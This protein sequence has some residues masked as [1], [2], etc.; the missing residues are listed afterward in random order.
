MN[1]ERI[2]LPIIRQIGQRPQ[3]SKQ[4]FRF[5]KWGD[6]YTPERFSWPYPIYDKMTA[7]GPVVYSRP[8]QQW[9]VSGHDEVLAVLRSP[10]SSTAALA[11]RMLAL[12]PYT[13]LS[14]TAVTNFRKW[15]LVTDPPMHTR[16][17][18]AVSRTFTPKRIADLEPRIRTITDDLLADLA[19]DESPDVVGGFTAALPIFA[20]GAILGL[21]DDRWDWLRS[22]S[23]QVGRMLEALDAFDPEVMNR[24]FDD[25]HETFS[26]L[27]AERRTA[28]RD[29]LVSALVSDESKLADDEVISMMTVLMFAGHETTTGL[30]GN[31]IVAL[32]QHPDQRTLLR[33]HPEIIDN[34]VEELLRFDT[35]AQFTG[36][37]TTGPIEIGDI[38]IPAGSNVALNIGAANR[39]RRRWPD[40]D[41]LLLDREDPRAISFGH[42]IHHCLGSAL[43]RL[44]MRVAIPA[45]VTAFGDYTVD[46]DDI[47]WKR[48]HTLRG[49][50]KL[51]VHR[52]SAAG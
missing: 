12:P 46:V 33:E 9:F 36:R 4:L 51:V 35:T 8:Y 43:A 10:N 5:A 1:V 25:L 31:S 14:D 28:P 30:L 26:E 29:D 39:D 2:L 49:P 45:F 32:A 15:L 21:P 50:T 38:T 24:C 7:D 42:G 37:N 48:S 16:L 20:I 17:R 6:P 40:A 23:A 44:E 34:A 52:A 22:S 18:A 19:D 3:L 41:R 47:E 27:I 11:D 13:K